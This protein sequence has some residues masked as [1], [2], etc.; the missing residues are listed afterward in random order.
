[1]KKLF[2][3]GRDFR[4][5]AGVILLFTIVPMLAVSL[6]IYQAVSASLVSQISASQQQKLESFRAQAEALIRDV[7]QT[8]T[9]QGMLFSKYSNYR[10][11]ADMPLNALYALL[12][13]GATGRAAN[14][15][16]KR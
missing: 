14:N 11:P 5:Y 12:R 3:K 4:I 15:Y 13:S 2:Q 9:Q 16:Q 8:A 1:M 10:N 6:V 7:E